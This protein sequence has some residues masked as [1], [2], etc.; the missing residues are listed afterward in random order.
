MRIQSWVVMS[1]SLIEFILA[2]VPIWTVV[3]VVF[4]CHGVG[5][6]TVSAN[7]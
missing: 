6:E 3:F 5:I 2:V 4:P 1:Y 7:F